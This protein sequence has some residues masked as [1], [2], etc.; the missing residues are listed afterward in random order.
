LIVLFL[1]DVYHVNY[2]N[3][4]ITNIFPEL[5]R[6]QYTVWANEVTTTMGVMVAIHMTASMGNGLNQMQML[7]CLCTRSRDRDGEIVVVT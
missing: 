2:I 5:F 4:T 6:G 3:E 1:E 7:S